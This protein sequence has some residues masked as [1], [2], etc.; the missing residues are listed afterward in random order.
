MQ[1]RKIFDEYFA[2][3][4]LEKC[5][6]KKFFNLQISDKPDL[7]HGNEIGIE[8][9]NCMPKEVAEAFSLWHR[10]AKQGEQ[11]PP[12]VLE[13]L[14][15]LNMVRVENGGLIWDQGVQ[16]EYFDEFPMKDFFNA[17]SKKLEKLNNK[18]ACY[19][20]LKSYELFVSSTL[21]ITNF[22]TTFAV[23][24][25]LKTLN[26][27]PKKFDNIYLLTINQ[28][29][30]CFDMNSNAFQTKYLYKRLDSLVQKSIRLIQEDISEDKENA[31]K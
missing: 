7:R 29:L 22:K 18:N 28:T 31:V 12:R 2:K 10:V 21:Y 27:K 13:R 11:T 20:E 15:Q 9:T 30:L 25:K 16:S 19:A 6:P 17:V 5:F 3:I 1:K 24:E 23:L 8:V 14:K 4:V 26:T